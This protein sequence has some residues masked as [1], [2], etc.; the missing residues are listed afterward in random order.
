MKGSAFLRFF[1]LIDAQEAQQMTD[2]I[3]QGCERV[4]TR[5]W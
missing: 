4:D 1:G 5:E 3:R 2:A